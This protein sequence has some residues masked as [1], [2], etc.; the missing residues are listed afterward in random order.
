[1]TQKRISP[2]GVLVLSMSR[3][4]VSK[5]LLYRTIQYTIFRTC[6]EDVSELTKT[7]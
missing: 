6:A 1:M 3:A 4:A 2:F 7:V 5:C